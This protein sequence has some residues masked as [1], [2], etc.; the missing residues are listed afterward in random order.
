MLL[1]HGAFEEGEVGFA[2]QALGEGGLDGRIRKVTRLVGLLERVVTEV[3]ELP[4]AVV[5]LDLDAPQRGEIVDVALEHCENQLIAEAVES[6]AWGNA[7][8]RDRLQR[9]LVDE[10][11]LQSA[12]FR[13][14]GLAE[15]RSS[16]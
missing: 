10:R 12:S 5:V 3:V 6:G 15:A 7:D 2:L 9:M 4:L 14:S 16:R 11:A 8:V 1:A 13:A